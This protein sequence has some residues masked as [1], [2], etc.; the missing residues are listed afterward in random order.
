[1]MN[2]IKLKLAAL[3]IVAT[4]GLYAFSARKPGSIK[5]SVTPANAAVK[6]WAISGSDTLK[7]G[8]DRGSFSINDVKP[9][10][11]KVIIE[12]MPPYKNMAEEG[13]AVHDGQQT[14]IGEI[15]LQQ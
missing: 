15:R 7:A 10:V 14:D 9:G 4:L 11:Y 2:A 5:G 12:A 6:A 13:V 8:I 3:S 1:M